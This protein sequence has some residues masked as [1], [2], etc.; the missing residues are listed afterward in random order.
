[1]NY[2]YYRME[3]EE[4]YKATMCPIC[5]ERQKDTGENEC[6]FCY[7][8]GKTVSSFINTSTPLHKVLD[9]ME[10]KTYEQR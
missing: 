10:Y 2:K 4:E 3:D 6:K 8:I 5:D 7:R 1:M 9:I